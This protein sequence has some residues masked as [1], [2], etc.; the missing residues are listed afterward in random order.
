MDDLQFV[1]DA[2]KARVNTKKHGVSFDEA[3]T[4][5]LDESALLLGDP[6]HSEDENR[7]LLLGVS[8]RLRLLVMCHC[9]RESDSE[10]RLIMARKAERNEREQYKERCR[11]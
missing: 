4:V 10:I 3:Q 1:W 5:F 2:R 11:S 8:A 6:D 7:F 9:Y